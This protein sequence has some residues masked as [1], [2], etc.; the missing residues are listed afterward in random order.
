MKIRVD[1]GRRVEKALEEAQARVSARLVDY[2][3]VL[4]LVEVAE[5]HLAEKGIALAYASGCR[6]W[7]NPVVA[8][9]AYGGWRA[10]T[11]RITIERGSSA[12]FLVGVERITINS[13]RGSEH[14]YGCHLTD[15]AKGRA[16]EMFEKKL[17]Y[18]GAAR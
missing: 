7:Y 11:T 17:E 16:M 14:E 15:R 9:N 3:D 12:W 6:C 5:G 1:N 18:M 10:R 2:R 8:V 13:G 4:K